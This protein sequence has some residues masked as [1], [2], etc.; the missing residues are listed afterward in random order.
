MKIVGTIEARMGSSRLPGK[1]MMQIWNEKSLLEI[2]VCRFMQ[3]K[4]LDG[5]V[6]ATKK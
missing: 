2:V 5:I 1:T 4:N 3:C 6:V